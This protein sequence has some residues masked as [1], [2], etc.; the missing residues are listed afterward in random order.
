MQHRRGAPEPGSGPEA[1]TDPLLEPPEPQSQSRT[2]RPRLGSTSPSA[3]LHPGHET[4]I[5]VHD[6]VASSLAHDDGGF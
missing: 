1:Q 3:P 4:G 6:N 2:V 5:L